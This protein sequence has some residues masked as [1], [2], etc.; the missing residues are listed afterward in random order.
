[1]AASTD[2]SVA[3]SLLAGLGALSGPRHGGAGAALLALLD[4][5]DGP[6]KRSRS[7]QVRSVSAWLKL[8]DTQW[9]MM[10]QFGHD[11]SLM[12]CAFFSEV[13]NISP[14]R[15]LQ[16]S[17]EGVALF[18]QFEGQALCPWGYIGS[19]SGVPQIPDDLSRRSTRQP[20]AKELNRSRGRVL[21]R[22]LDR[23]S[24]V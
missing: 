16:R 8:P 14:F 10:R 13:S 20:W 21:V 6:V 15:F 24:L 1:V 17:I 18:L 2:A 3:A 19:T 23:G 7:T 4:E 12:Q 11:R 5:R 22:R 9:H